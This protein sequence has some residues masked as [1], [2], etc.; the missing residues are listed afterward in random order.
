MSSLNASHEWTYVQD[1][2]GIVYCLGRDTDQETSEAVATYYE[3]SPELATKYGIDAGTHYRRFIY[4]GLPEERER[5]AQ[6]ERPEVVERL[7]TQ[8]SLSGVGLTI[9]SCAVTPSNSRYSEVATWL[10]SKH[11]R[12]ALFRAA[13]NIAGMVLDRA[14]IAIEDLSLYGGAAFGVVNNT[15]KN[16]DDVDFVFN[17][18]QREELDGALTELK[19]EYTWNEID[20]HGRLSPSRQLLKAKRWSTSQVRLA[21]PHPFSIDLKIRR[22]LG[23]ASLWDYMPEN[24]AMV[25]FSEKLKVVDDTEALC[26]SPALRCEDKE[27]RERI[28]L[29]DGYQYIGCAVTG[30]E[31]TVSGNRYIDS[32]VVW[33]T[34]VDGHGVVPDFRNVP[35]T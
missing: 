28:V 10:H 14:G 4:Q 7:L 35:I 2:L 12:A 15:T 33:V 5:L 6:V 32:D 29:L 19:S 9:N 24:V 22:D 8:T 27:G 13:L 1:E 3:T 30:D 20:P 26:I 17:M 34:Q 23:G 21:V 18:Q 25:R 11:P 16:V 31:I